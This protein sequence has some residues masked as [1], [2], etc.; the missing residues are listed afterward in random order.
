MVTK[1]TAEEIPAMKENFAELHGGKV[2]V[3]DNPSGGTIFMVDLPIET[4]TTSN[5]TAHLGS[6]RSF[7][8]RMQV[9]RH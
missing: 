9:R 1:T 2:D 4:S 6:L 3:T 5:S 7:P 8:T